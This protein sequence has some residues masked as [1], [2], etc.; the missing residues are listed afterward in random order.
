MPASALFQT[1]R[2]VPTP[3]GPVGTIIGVVIGNQ[4]GATRLRNLPTVP[5]RSPLYISRCFEPAAIPPTLNLKAMTI[6]NRH[7]NPATAATR[8]AERTCKKL[9]RDGGAIGLG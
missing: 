2:F 4:V 1:F 3:P 5:G 8:R 9:R 6:A 7:T